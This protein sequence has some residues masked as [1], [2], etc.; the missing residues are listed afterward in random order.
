VRVKWLKVAERLGD[1]LDAEQIPDTNRWKMYI[2]VDI[3]G[4]IE[5]PLFD[6]VIVFLFSLYP[7]QL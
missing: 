3:P 2:A 7:E 1:L 4:G 5:S 6:I